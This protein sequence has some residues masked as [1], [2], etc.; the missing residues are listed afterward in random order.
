MRDEAEAAAAV[1]AAAG[2]SG[3][4]EGNTPLV[5]SRWIGPRLGLRG[6]YFK[7]E[8]TNPTGSYKDRFAARFVARLRDAGVGRDLGAIDVRDERA[9]GCR[10]KAKERNDRERRIEHAHG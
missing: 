4:G 9:A 7:L 5:P 3:L 2:G 10:E 8:Q 1:T 6:L